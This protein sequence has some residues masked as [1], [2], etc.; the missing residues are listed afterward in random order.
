MVDWNLSRSVGNTLPI[1]RR[2]G[3]EV[4]CIGSIEE[5]NAGIR[6]AN[7]ILGAEVNKHYLHGGILDLQTYVDEVSC[8]CF[9][10]PM[11][12]VPDLIVYGSI[13]APCL[14]TMGAR[15]VKLKNGSS[16]PFGGRL[17]DLSPRFI[18]EGWTDPRRFY[19]LH[20]IAGFDS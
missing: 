8:K 5:L 19:T 15:S 1:W 16:S 2:N 20:A 12:R 3:E 18:A 6:K 7:E 13:V 14:C 10:K 4:V 11:K 17:G 9:R